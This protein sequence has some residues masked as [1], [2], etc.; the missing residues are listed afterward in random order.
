MASTSAAT[1]HPSEAVGSTTTHGHA[2][3][4]VRRHRRPRHRRPGATARHAPRRARHGRQGERVGVQRGEVATEHWR[5]RWRSPGGRRTR[6]ATSR[7]NLDFGYMAPAHTVLREGLLL[8][9]ASPCRGVAGHRAPQL[10]DTPSG[11][12][13][14]RQARSDQ[15]CKLYTK[16]GSCTGSVYRTWVAAQVQLPPNPQVWLQPNLY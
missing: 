4:R 15:T 7:T 16:P 14:M 11:R 5:P 8:V 12:P 3:D 9:A 13:H 1:P 2:R 10:I 6:S